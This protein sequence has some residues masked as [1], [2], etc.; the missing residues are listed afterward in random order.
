M[1]WS[2]K[3]VNKLVV[4]KEETITLPSSATLGYSSEIDFLRPDPS[5]AN[6]Y[7][8]IGF[9]PSAVSGTNLD[10]DL[11]GAYESGGTKF[12][13]KADIITAPTATGLV[14]GQVDLNAYPAPYYYLSWLPDANESANTISVYVIFR[15]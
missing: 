2:K 15:E 9:N 11:F 13:L 10:I 5:H 14:F 3:T 1:A 4:A 12:N 7:V 6:K 8:E